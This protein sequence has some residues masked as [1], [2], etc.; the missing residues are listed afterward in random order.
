MAIRPNSSLFNKFKKQINSF[1][2]GK[3]NEFIADNKKASKIGKYWIIGFCLIL[4]TGF[5]IPYNFKRIAKGNQSNSK[6]F[7]DEVQSKD[8]LNEANFILGKR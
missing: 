5:V 8:A 4:F 7:V 1:T 2:K 3:D 6:S